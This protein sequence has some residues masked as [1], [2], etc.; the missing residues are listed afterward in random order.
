MP[1]R[2]FPKIINKLMRLGALDASVEPLYMKKART[3]FKLLVLC[4]PELRDGIITAI[5]GLTTTFGA[6]VYVTGREKLSRKIVKVR[7]KYGPARTKLGYLGRELKT[8]APE[9][10]DYKRLAAKHRL[11]L[12]RAYRQVVKASLA[13]ILP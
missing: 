2:S 5:F 13:S 7:T 8:I 6:R 12:G 3:G 1:P 11:P 4:E 10:E 9:Y